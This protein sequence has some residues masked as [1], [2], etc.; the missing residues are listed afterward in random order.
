MENQEDIQPFATT[1]TTE[2][3][4]AIFETN[5][6][7]ALGQFVNGLLTGKNAEAEKKWLETNN[8]LIDEAQEARQEAQISRKEA[9]EAR[10]LAKYSSSLKSKY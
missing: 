10:N 9:E 2:T 1:V 6:P 5:I 7:E 8:K 4:T 3:A